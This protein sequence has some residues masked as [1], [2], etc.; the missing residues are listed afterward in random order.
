MDACCKASKFLQCGT[1]NGSVCG[2]LDVAGARAAAVD[3]QAEGKP[4]ALAGG[5]ELEADGR[6]QVAP[7]AVHVRVI[8]IIAG[9][10]AVS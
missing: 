9:R 5:L 7:L 3:G 8:V 4:P 2:G 10:G 1:S 6:A